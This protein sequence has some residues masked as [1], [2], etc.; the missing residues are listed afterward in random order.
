MNVKA[1]G[2]AESKREHLENVCIFNL[3]IIDLLITVAARSKAWVC[4][5]WLAGITDS[6]PSRR[7]TDVCLL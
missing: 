1:K 6:N 5:L 3:S 7:A 2:S 4:G